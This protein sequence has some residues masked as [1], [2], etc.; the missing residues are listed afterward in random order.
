[1]KEIKI[2]IK[3]VSVYFGYLQALNNITL[4]IYDNRVTSIIGPSGC[5]KTSLLKSLNRMNEL[6]KGFKLKG[7]ILID[8]TNI[9][10]KDIDVINLRKLVGMVFQQAN[11]F[12]KSIYENLIFAPSIN[13]IKDKIAIAEIIEEAA[14]LAGIW[15]EIKDRLKES[16]Y[17]LSA[18]QQ[19]RLCIA[20]LL[21]ANPDILLLDEPAAALDPISTNKIEELIYELKKKYT[22]VVVTHNM[23]QAARISDYIAF[24]YMGQLIEYDKTSKIFTNPAN[25]QTEDYITGRFG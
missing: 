19:Q 24:L 1:M 18:G 17:N 11:L 6:V 25:K 5:G 3:N 4:D 21:T 7:E 16:P 9:Y 10:Q 12:P 8:G 13:G 23:Q 14:T 2:I 22:V 20:R 15:D